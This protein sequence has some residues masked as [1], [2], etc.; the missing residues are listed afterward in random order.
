MTA[1]TN[2]FK[3]FYFSK[4]PVKK[5]L[6]RLQCV[7]FLNYYT[8]YTNTNASRRIFCNAAG[9]VTMTLT[10]SRTVDNVSLCVCSSWICC[11]HQRPSS[12]SSGEIIEHCC[13]SSVVRSP[14]CWM[15]SSKQH[16]ASFPTV[17]LG[18]SLFFFV[19][20][21]DLFL[22]VPQQA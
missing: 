6:N 11:M 5:I 14:C 10:I 9:D 3:C 13:L 18:S 8:N 12:S 22:W 17:A 19:V 21:L 20:F 4:S 16:A 7:F 1:F 15:V 2:W